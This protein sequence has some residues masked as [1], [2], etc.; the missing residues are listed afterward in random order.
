MDRILVYDSKG[1]CVDIFSKSLYK[2]LNVIK[3]DINKVASISSN[4]TI[5]F[6]IY[7]YE[8]LYEYFKLT[9][10]HSL[11]DLV[12][13]SDEMIYVLKKAKNIKIFTI[14]KYAKLLIEISKN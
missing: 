7:D 10:K 6:I 3:I 8:D 11:I 5:I 12:V 9:I 4:Q 13:A 14:E 1:Y 2:L